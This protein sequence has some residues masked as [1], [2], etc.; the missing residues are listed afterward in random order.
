[1][2]ILFVCTGNT[3]RSPMAEGIFNFLQKQQSSNSFSSSA[4]IMVIPGSCVS[5][6]SVDALKQYNTDISDHIPKQIDKNLISENDLVLTMSQSHKDYLENL[7]PEFSDKIYTLGEYT[8]GGDIQDPYGGSF[9]L[10]K[11]CA[12][13]IYCAIKVLIEKIKENE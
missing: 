2:K 12:D 3:C 8:S 9:N 11:Q 6:Y 13:D 10:Y 7:F 1:M 5:K 4:G